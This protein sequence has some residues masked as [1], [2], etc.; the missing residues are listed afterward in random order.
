MASVKKTISSD[1]SKGSDELKDVLSKMKG[2]QV[3]ILTSYMWNFAKEHHQLIIDVSVKLAES[4]GFKKTAEFLHV[5][6]FFVHY[7]HQVVDEVE[8]KYQNDLRFAQT[9]QGE[10]FNREQFDSEYHIQGNRMQHFITTVLTNYNTLEALA[11]LKVAFS[12]FYE[13]SSI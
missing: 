4:L 3:D 7:I 13:S 12:S 2:R 5:V 10:N 8:A 11:Y 9:S 6:Q 1:T